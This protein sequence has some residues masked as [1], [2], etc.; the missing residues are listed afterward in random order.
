MQRTHAVVGIMAQGLRW[1]WPWI[2]ALALSSSLACALNIAISGGPAGRTV[3]GSMSAAHASADRGR[4][5]LLKRCEASVADPMYAGVDMDSSIVSEIR[6]AM[7]N[8][9]DLAV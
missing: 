2:C 5:P 1:G 7:C 8:T 6:W 3:Q 4:S 9:G